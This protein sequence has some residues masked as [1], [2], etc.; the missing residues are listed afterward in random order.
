MQRAD[1]SIGLDDFV[2]FS[3]AR[4]TLYVQEAEAGYSAP[5]LTALNDTTNYGGTFNMSVGDRFSLGAKV[6][7]R[8][9]EQG[10]E[11]R[12]QE[13]NIGYKITDRW[14]LSAGYS[15]DERTDSS[16]IV[17][18]TQEQG[19]RADAVLQVGYDSKST[20]NI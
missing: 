16:T 5:G 11:S 3:E 4:L 19:E 17:P 1:I 6:D 8:V 9:Q 2:S 18:L 10:V 20:W 7:S 15:M 12:A 14:D 13:F